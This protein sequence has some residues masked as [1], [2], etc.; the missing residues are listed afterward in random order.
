MGHYN[1]QYIYVYVRVSMWWICLAF[2]TSRIHLDMFGHLSVCR[3]QETGFAVSSL[4]CLWTPDTG[5]V[6]LDTRH[7]C[8]VFGH[9]TQV[10]YLWTPDTSGVSLDI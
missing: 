9:L 5:V 8:C 2:I 7:R 6:S 1:L 4:L 3:V 10:V